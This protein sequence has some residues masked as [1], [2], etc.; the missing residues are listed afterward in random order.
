MPWHSAQQNQAIYQF[1][2]Q[3]IAFR[4]TYSE[5]LIHEPIIWQEVTDETGLL[6]F[7]IGTLQMT[8][9]TGTTDVMVNVTEDIL[10]AQALTGDILSPDGF[11]IA[12]I[13]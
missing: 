8:F 10:L 11:V 13:L 6:R 12:R 1:M 7:N 3:L 2:Q 9:N 4:K 5:M